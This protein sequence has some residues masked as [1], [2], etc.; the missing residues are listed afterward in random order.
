VWIGFSAA[1]AIQ[2]SSGA[3]VNGDPLFDTHRVAI[4]RAAL[5]RRVPTMCGWTS[6]VQAGAM[7]GYALDIVDMWRQSA[8]Y[9]AQVLRG[10]DPGTIPIEQ[11]TTVQ[12]AVNMRTAR[13]LGI[14]ISPSILTRADEVIE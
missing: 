10:I 11:P 3:H 7:I 6:W 12:V 13:A 5:E 8:R 1:T 2:H 14:Q 9:I 4:F